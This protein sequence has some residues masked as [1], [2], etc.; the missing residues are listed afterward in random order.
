[1][2]RSL[3]R[4]AGWSV[5]GIAA[6]LALLFVAGVAV[7]YLAA[8]GTLDGDRAML[9]IM[10]AFAVVGMAGAYW[11]GLAW[12]RNIDEAAR[13]AHKAAWYW[14]GVGGMS[15][16]GVLMILAMLP[17]ARTVAIPAFNVGDAHPAAYAASGAFALMLL[18]VMGYTLFWGFWWLRR[19]RP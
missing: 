6:V 7:G 17:Q 3:W 1:M 10:V 14:G 5:L 4:V 18:M 15:V 13:E 8:H 11:I 19:S 12:M 16:G 9:W 2:S